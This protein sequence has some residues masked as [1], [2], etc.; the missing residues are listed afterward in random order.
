[1]LLLASVLWPIDP[2]LSNE[3]LLNQEALKGS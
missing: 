2:S 1:M 3:A